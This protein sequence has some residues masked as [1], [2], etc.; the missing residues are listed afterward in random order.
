[1]S[2]YRFYYQQLMKE[3][4]NWTPNRATIIIKLLWRKRKA[5]FTKKETVTRMKKA[6]MK[7]SARKHFRKVKGLS[8]SEAK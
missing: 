7:L 8:A 1:M 3:H 2:F 4:P 6:P 5:E